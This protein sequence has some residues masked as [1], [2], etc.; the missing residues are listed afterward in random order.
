M[1]TIFLTF[2]ISNSSLT[3]F[4]LVLCNKLTTKHKVVI[5][6][7]KLEPHDF[8]VSPDIAIY[9]WPSSR[10]TTFNDF[11]FLYK[12]VLQYK[13]ETM[14]SMFGAVNMFLLVGFLLRVK[15][16]IA[17]SH[18]LFA[19]TNESKNL[20]LRK[21]YIFK[22]ATMSITNSNSTKQDLMK[23]FAVP[24]HKISVV[25]NAVRAGEI[26][27]DYDPNKILYV[28]SLHYAKGVD[29][30]IAAMPQ[31]I[32]Q[33]P[34][35]QLTL[36]GGYL[37]GNAIKNYR[38]QI[39]N[40]NIENNV[41]CVGRLSKQMVVKAFSE[42]YLSVVPSFLEAF[43]FVVIESFSVGTPVV[44]SDTSGIA[45][46]IRDGKDGL[47]F[48]PGN[49]NELAEKIIMVLGNKN[50]RAEFSRNCQERFH[51]QFEIDTATNRLCTKINSL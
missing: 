14:I 34:E 30:L 13:P 31:V 37:H 18:S 17:W 26:N 3:E 49:V 24:E 39:K 4:F 41:E 11:W 44:G 16:R 21:K 32:K 45:E 1:K 23:N 7:D 22:L 48:E 42:A 33:F 46:I 20:D 10:P 43:G 8:Y 29:T 40:L 38:E 6:T 2:T 5:I 9:T 47:L 19:K 35:V 51:E 36:V 12:K 15:N 27:P 25:Y 50:L 28:G